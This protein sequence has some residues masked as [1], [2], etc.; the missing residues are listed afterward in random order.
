MLNPLGEIV[1][2]L[3]HKNPHDIVWLS[4]DIVLL[5]HCLLLKYAIKR[6]WCKIKTKMIYTYKINVCI[7]IKQLV[8]AYFMAKRTPF[9]RVE[10]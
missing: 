1:S 7:H 5:N 2:F 10:Q 9:A 3:Q 8:F 6:V 4:Y